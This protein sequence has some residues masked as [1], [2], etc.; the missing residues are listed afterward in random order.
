MDWQV[1]RIMFAPQP[2]PKIY[3]NK[4]YLD[5]IRSQTCEVCG[6]LGEP[7]HIRRSYF[8][9]GMGKKSH[10]YATICL[11]REHHDP[12]WESK[13]FVERVII[14]NLMEYIECEKK[15]Q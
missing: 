9:A 14:N 10:D 2:K 15:S 3:K 1:G 11:C 6:K 7:H 12:K 13:L 5:F 8:G 4:R